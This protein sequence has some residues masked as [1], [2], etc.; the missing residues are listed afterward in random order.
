MADAESSPGPSA[1]AEI[2][3]PVGPGRY[4]P[5]RHPTHFEP[6]LFASPM[7]WQ[8]QYL[9]SSWQMLPATSSNAL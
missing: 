2:T 8:E 7:T 5:P 9:L 1:A 6:S 4:Y 3:D